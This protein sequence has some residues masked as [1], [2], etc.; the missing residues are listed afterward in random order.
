MK[1]TVKI[2]AALKRKLFN[3]FFLKTLTQLDHSI[4]RA[5]IR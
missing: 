4:F 3:S 5:E 1:L 2:N